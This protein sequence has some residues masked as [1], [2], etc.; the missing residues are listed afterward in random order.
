VLRTQQIANLDIG[1]P[2]EQR[3][4]LGRGSAVTFHTGIRL[5]EAKASGKRQRVMLAEAV[6]QVAG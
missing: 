4:E 3:I 6:A 2:G 5:L 1:E